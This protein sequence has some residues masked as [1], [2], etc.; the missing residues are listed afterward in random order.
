MTKHW[1]N[2][3]ETIKINFEINEE[4]E[5]IILFDLTHNIGNLF[6]LCSQMLVNN[7][8][9][10]N[11]K[12]AIAVGDI[13]SNIASLELV[14]NLPNSLYTDYIG[15][16]IET[17]ISHK[18]D[19]LDIH[20]SLLEELS[21]ISTNIN[22]PNSDEL[23]FHLNQM[24]NC[25]LDICLFYNIKPLYCIEQ[26]INKNSSNIPKSNNNKDKEIYYDL[27]Y[28]ND[29]RRDSKLIASSG[30]TEFLFDIVMDKRRN[31]PYKGINVK[32][33]KNK[34]PKYYFNE[35][36]IIVDFFVA[37]DYIH[38]NHEFVSINYTPAFRKLLDIAAGKIYTG[39]LING[40]LMSA[41][42]LLEKSED[43]YSITVDESA[44]PVLMTDEIKNLENLLD[45]IT[46][47]RRINRGENIK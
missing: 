18:I 17:T 46:N 22:L 13:F 5:N 23:Q 20:S 14:Y 3:K 41:I 9:K 10:A 30:K 19:L 38:Q 33:G 31:N 34:K 6:K 36:N 32:V 25:F 39:F 4:T 37:S 8:I 2:F 21:I 45:F 29:Y 15:L 44:I 28:E 42:P 16:P 47:I 35:N 40:E 27:N 1:F 24:V 43:G 7:K 12:I 11:K 26:F